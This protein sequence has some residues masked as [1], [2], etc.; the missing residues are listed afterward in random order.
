MEERINEIVEKYLDLT[1]FYGEDNYPN[2]SH[3]YDDPTS[4]IKESPIEHFEEEVTKCIKEN[5]GEQVT[6]NISLHEDCDGDMLV[7]NYVFSYL[8]DGK[9]MTQACELQTE[10]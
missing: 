5:G 7:A 8:M 1:G 2:K 9:V 10:Y 4:V 3:I 6:C